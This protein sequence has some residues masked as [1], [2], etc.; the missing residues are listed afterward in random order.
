MKLVIFAGVLVL[1]AV[2]VYVVRNAQLPSSAVEISGGASA[3]WIEVI[4]PS[5]KE[6]A[7]DGTIIRELKSG[8]TIAAGR[9]ITA[10]ASGIADIHF[11][12]GSVARIDASSELA[13]NE[14]NFEP[15]TET[16]RVRLMLLAGRTW[17]RAL[18]LAS[19][20]SLWEV[21]TANAVATIRGTAFG[22]EYRDGASLLFV[23]QDEVSFVPL[24]P[25]TNERLEAAGVVVRP[26]E[27]V[28]VKS[29]D[30]PKLRE[31][32][33]I[34]KPAAAPEEI[35][36]AEWVKRSRE[37][38]SALEERIETIRARGLEGSSLRRALREEIQAERKSVIKKDVRENGKT[39]EQNVQPAGQPEP[40][41]ES[42]ARK[43]RPAAEEPLRPNAVE[44]PR[45]PINTPPPTPLAPLPTTPRKAKIESLRILFEN[46][47]DIAAV[48]LFEEDAV[49][50]RAVARLSDGTERDI[51]REAKWQV[52]GDI[53][54]VDQAKGVFIPRLRADIRELGKSF[55]NI[56]AT[57]AD[58]DTGE[59]F[60]SATPIFEVNTKI[61]ERTP[62]AG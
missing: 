18:Q 38:D 32:S 61:T 13:L 62:E 29:E 6:R 51:T 12:D 44:Q 24:D 28:E 10:D 53:G 4:A 47:T 33:A 54:Q 27:F 15:E 23:D 45:L 9:I 1:A 39:Q 3:P 2:G 21:E 35:R 30:V 42:E 16:L 36:N 14:V 60:F 7:E 17:S 31:K 59:L 46:V 26:Q 19:P 40:R 41:Q 34:L 55:G 58:P 5:I 56:T 22:I 25:Q 49:S 37:R 57:F 48:K 50:I 20:E 43:P 52:L 8:D 11:P